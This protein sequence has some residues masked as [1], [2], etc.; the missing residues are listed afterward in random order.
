MLDLAAVHQRR[1]GAFGVLVELVDVLLRMLAGAFRGLSLRIQPLRAPDPPDLPALLGSLD[2][3]IAREGARGLEP[4]RR[5]DGGLACDVGACEPADAVPHSTESPELEQRVQRMLASGLERFVPP[6]L[7]G[8]DKGVVVLQRGAE[9]A[10]ALRTATRGF[11]ERG[12]GVV[13]GVDDVLRQREGIREQGAAEPDDAG[14]GSGEQVAVRVRQEAS[15]SK[16]DGAGAGGHGRAGAGLRPA[17]SGERA[18][19]L[20][21]LAGPK[22]RAVNLKAKPGL[23]AL[24]SDEALALLRDGI[25][26]RA[27]AAELVALVGGQRVQVRADVSREQRVK[28]VGVLSVVLLTHHAAIGPERLAGVAVAL[29]VERLDD[30]VAGDAA[31]GRDLADGL[32]GTTADDLALLVRV[33]AE[34]RE[35]GELVL[36]GKARSSPA[37]TLCRPPRGVPDRRHPADRLGE[38]AYT[39]VWAGRTWPRRSGAQDL[40]MGDDRTLARLRLAAPRCP[41][42]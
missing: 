35:A 41:A 1:V 19:D 30:P 18:V 39:P 36:C 32:L 37:G 9:L 27:R 38:H 42:A 28:G 33:L 10:Q 24:A 21:A 34:D 20:G 23:G 5:Q 40:G 7:R 17:G 6:T 3:G 2:G 31:L 8:E 29:V 13:R 16:G 26:D 14:S 25:A 11:V 22:P 12:A 15:G 4:G